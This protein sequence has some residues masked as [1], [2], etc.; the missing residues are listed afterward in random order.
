[1]RYEMHFFYF[2][3]TDI[4]LLPPAINMFNLNGI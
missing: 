4:N 3:H 2:M 1:M